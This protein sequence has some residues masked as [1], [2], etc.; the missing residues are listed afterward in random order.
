VKPKGEGRIY[1]ANNDAHRE[2]QPLSRN[3]ING[4]VYEY[5]VTSM[6]SFCAYLEK[7]LVLRGKRVRIENDTHSHYFANGDLGRMYDVCDLKGKAIIA[8]AASLG[9]EVSDFQA[10]N[11]QTVEA[12]IRQAEER[13]KRFVFFE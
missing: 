11:R 9:W 6:A 2:P 10:L 3:T 7:P 8:T 5:V 13:G 1:G 4:V 12:Y